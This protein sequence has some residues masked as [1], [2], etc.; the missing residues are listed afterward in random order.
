MKTKRRYI[1]RKTKKR[2]GKRKTK[3]RGGKRKRC[4]PPSRIINRA[5]KSKNYLAKIDDEFEIDN[6]RSDFTNE[7]IENWINQLDDPEFKKQMKKICSALKKNR[8]KKK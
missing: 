2:G 4:C 7:D 3:K 6:M 5:R 8:N 1:K